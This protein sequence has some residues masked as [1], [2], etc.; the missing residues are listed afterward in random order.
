MIMHKLGVRSQLAAVAQANRAGWRP[1]AERAH[2]VGEFSYRSAGDTSDGRPL[3]GR[4]EP[5]PSPVGG[6]TAGS[7]TA[8]RTRPAILDRL[9]C[10][11][12]LA[13][14]VVEQLE[15]NDG[16]ISRGGT[17]PRPAWDA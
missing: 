2:L 10:R 12:S 15:T 5:E 11:P 14:L 6:V 7:C 13:G 3:S 8:F 16:P 17:R 1:R 9:L 4:A